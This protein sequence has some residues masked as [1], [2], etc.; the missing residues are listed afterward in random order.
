M[1]TTTPERFLLAYDATCGTCRKISREVA[2]ASGDRLAVVPLDRPDVRQWRAQALGAHAPWAPTLLRTHDDEVRAW[3]GPVMAVPLIRRLGPRRTISVVCAL[4]RMRHDESAPQAAGS[5][6]PSL[7]VL[8]SGTLA[9]A[10][11]LLTGKPPTTA[12]RENSVAARWVSAHRDELPRS[13]DGV[14]AHPVA[15]QR[16]IF[17]ASPP[18]VQSRLWIE[19]LERDRASRTGMTGPQEALFARAIELAGDQRLFHTGRELDSD[20]R[21]RLIELRQDALHEFER[22]GDR[23]LLLTLGATKPHQKAR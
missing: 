1:T 20:L 3:T 22:A 4:G 5:G 16:A 23:R 8:W 17:D 14:T 12:A 18:E 2:R 21:Q 9:A 13:Y 11:M 19:A 7:P 6:T 10:R 15:Y